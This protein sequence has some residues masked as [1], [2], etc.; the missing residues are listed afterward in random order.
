[1]GVDPDKV[2]TTIDRDILKDHRVKCICL[3]NGKRWVIPL[4]QYMDDYMLIVK[5]VNRLI[6]VAF[7]YLPTP[8]KEGMGYNGS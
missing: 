6:D 5:Q 7:D 4:S 2:F 3:C 1:M 8:N